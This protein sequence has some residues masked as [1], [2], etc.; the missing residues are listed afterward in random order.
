MSRLIFQA[1]VVLTQVN[2]LSVDTWEF[3][4][5]FSDNEGAFLATDIIVGDVFVIDTSSYNVGTL[6]SYVVT[7]ILSATSS[8]GVVAVVFDINNATLDYPDLGYSIGV[9][10]IVTR[11]SPNYKLLNAP[12]ADIQLISDKFAT[13]LTNYNFTEIVDKFVMGGGGGADQVLDSDTPTPV[14]LGGIPAGSTFDNVPVEVVLRDLLYPYQIPTFTAFAISGQQTQLEVGQPISAGAKTFTWSTSNASN[15]SPNTISVVDITN[16]TTLVATSSNDGT[17]VI[18]ISNITK[19][20]PT[21]HTWRITGVNTRSTPF[22]RDFAVTW[23]WRRFHGESTLQTLTE[24]QTQALRVSAFA[25]G[26]AGT[27]SF[28]GGGYKWIAY[29]TSFGT[30]TLFKDTNTN[31]DVPM[32]P[33]TTLMLTNA[34]GISTS[35]RIHRTTNVLGASINILVS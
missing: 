35:Y 14:T 34:Y 29:P 20:T 17:E 2:Q 10:S 27:Y 1:K 25:T 21:T 32:E 30:A 7:S 16:S 11:P 8:S 26:F 24:S 31:L 23:V 4:Y 15:V 33:A 12:A 18:T 9:D 28:V 3:H 19:N 6:T 13:Y 22:V 5:N